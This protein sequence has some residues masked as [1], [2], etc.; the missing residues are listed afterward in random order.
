MI[1]SIAIYRY[2]GI[3]SQLYFTGGPERLQQLHMQCLCTSECANFRTC[4]MYCMHEIYVV[5][6][7]MSGS[8]INSVVFIHYTLLHVPDLQFCSRLTLEHLRAVCGGTTRED[9]GM[10]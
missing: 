6:G 7:M 8:D 2:I 9:P 3:L 4:A 5:S 1:V 10:S